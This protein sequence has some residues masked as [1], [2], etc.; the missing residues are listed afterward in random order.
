MD[1]VPIL[2][3]SSAA[4]LRM[5]IQDLPQALLITGSEGIGLTTISKYVASSL[6]ILPI[7]V[8]P[9]KEEKVDL[10]KGTITVGIIRRL[11]DQTK[12]KNTKKQLIVIDYAERMGTQAQNA[13]LKL[14]EEPGEAVHF[15]LVTHQPNRLLPTIRSRTQLIYIQKVTKAQSEAIL[16]DLDLKDVQKR[17]QI[18]FI[19]EGLP[20]EIYRLVR[21][22]DYFNARTQIIRDARELI[23]G[24]QYDKLKLAQAY[25]DKRSESLL[26][27]RDAA[28]ILRRSIVSHPQGSIITQINKIIIAHDKIEANGSIRLCLA[29]LVL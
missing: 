24:S 13:F 22:T 25:K 18:I 6:E 28:N 17:A 11:Y 19:A 29:R 27:L 23:Q 15:I 8:L 7:I 9:E 5:M 16:D 20:A 26:M 1:I 14:L 2:H 21:N 3:P 12:T 10:D 4:A